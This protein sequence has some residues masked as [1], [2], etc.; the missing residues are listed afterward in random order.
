MK[1]SK[2]IVANIFEKGLF[3]EEIERNFSHTD[4]PSA[5]I[6]N[7]NFVDDRTLYIEYLEGDKMNVKKE[8]ITFTDK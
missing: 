8:T 2:L 4:I 1:D 5:A 6:L 3:Y 7:A